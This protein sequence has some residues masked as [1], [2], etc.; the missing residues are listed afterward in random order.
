MAALRFAANVERLK[1][2]TDI[3]EALHQVARLA[4]L[5]AFAA[6]RVPPWGRR[7]DPRAFRIHKHP[8][9]PDQ[10]ETD[11]WPLYVKHGRSFLAEL[12]W[13]NRGP[14]TMTEALRMMKPTGE[15]RW[16][17]RLFYQY[18]ARDVFYVPNGVWMVAYWAPK[19][20]RL[21]APTQAALRLAANSV[22]AR[23]RAMDRRR[24]VTTG[25]ELSARQRAVLRFLGQGYSP[26]EIA[27]HLAIS[28]GTVKEHIERAT[29]KLGAKTATQ[30]A[31][32]AVRRYIVLVF[33]ITIVLV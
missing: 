9:M 29:K 3:L 7:N 22:A 5:N 24:A 13:L 30:A 4:G 21:D 2:P 18:G 12:A 20:L 32:E 23:L 28:H 31:V 10:F 8:S 11:F 26:H 27:T 1:D 6:W 33:A 15:E 16:I 14:F 17:Q 25:P 19:P